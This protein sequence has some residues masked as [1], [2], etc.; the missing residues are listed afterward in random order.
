MI[1]QPD[2]PV[3]DE[4]AA[5]EAELDD[6]GERIAL[7]RQA[8]L[9]SR[10]AASLGL[11]VFVAVLLFVPAYRTAPVLLLAFTA[12]LGGTV[13]LGATKS[14]RDELRGQQTEAEARKGGLFDVVAAR[15]GWADVAQTR[16]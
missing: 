16:H 9:L 3:S 14:T 7:C 13:W 15:N 8:M 5:I 4:L 6:L 1:S 10:I 2:D 11:A 12:V